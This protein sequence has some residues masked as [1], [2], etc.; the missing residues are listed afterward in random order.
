M[1][2]LFLFCVIFLIL[3]R[4]GNLS[5]PTLLDQIPALQYTLYRSENKNNQRNM[6]NCIKRIDKMFYL[7]YN[8]NS[9]SKYANI[10]NQTSKYLGG[11]NDVVFDRSDQSYLLYD[12]KGITYL[13]T[14]D[15]SN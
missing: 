15:R 14:C 13:C 6:E 8:P 12:R 4:R 1:E 5:F 3:Y 2:N 7:R 9:S 11:K 10:S